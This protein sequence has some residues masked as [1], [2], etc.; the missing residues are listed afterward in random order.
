MGGVEIKI[1]G[2]DYS[3]PYR[4]QKYVP[5]GA[6]SVCSWCQKSNC[7]CE[8]RIKQI[9]ELHEKIDREYGQVVVS[10]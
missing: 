2:I 1:D 5:L 3:I 4:G 6:G 9:E 10:R 8:K 7:T